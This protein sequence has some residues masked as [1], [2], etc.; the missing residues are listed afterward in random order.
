MVLE[1]HPN[2]EEYR[3]ERGL[4]WS[5]GSVECR[6]HET[7]ISVPLEDAPSI[8]T[9]G[10]HPSPAPLHEMVHA[11][12]CQSLGSEAMLSIPQLVP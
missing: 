1:L 8:L 2:L 11:M 12:V 10:P 4:Q 5:R 9:E 6:E 3:A 7:V